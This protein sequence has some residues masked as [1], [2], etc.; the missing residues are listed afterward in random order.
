MPFA[1]IIVGILL[2]VSGVK[3][4]QSDLYKLVESDFTGTNNFVYWSLSILVIGCLG[5]VPQLR[6]I[7]RMF[8]LLVILVLFLKKGSGFFTQFQQAVSST[9]SQAMSA[10]KG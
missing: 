2:L 1:L 5:Y 3:G 7:S 4:T 9:Q 6:S 8:M 10:S